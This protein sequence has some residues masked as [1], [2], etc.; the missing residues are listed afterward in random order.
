M[1]NRI[2]ALFLCIGMLLCLCACNDGHASPETPSST[3]PT[4]HTEPS[5]ST[6]DSG[7]VI[8]PSSSANDLQNPQGNTSATAPTDRHSGVQQNPDT[9]YLV[10]HILTNRQLQIYNR[11]VAAVQNYEQEIDF[12]NCKSTDLLYAFSAANKYNPDLFWFP[13][14]YSMN[15]R[16]T[17]YT[18]TLYYPYSIEQVAWMSDKLQ[19]AVDRLLTDLPSGLDA[20]ATELYLHD[21]L[22]AATEY[23]FN[24]RTNA[25]NAYGALVD[26]SAVCEGYARA[27][28]LLLH[29]SGLECLLVNGTLDDE[30]HMWNIVKLDGQ[31]Y[32]LDP[33]LND[34]DNRRSH[35][36]FNLTDLAISADHTIDRQLSANVN[37]IPLDLDFNLPIPVCGEIAACYFVKTNSMI[38]TDEHLE[39]VLQTKLN[40]KQ[41][42]AGDIIELGFADTCSLSYPA[43]GSPVFAAFEN[44]ISNVVFAAGYYKFYLT[45]IPGSKG[46]SIRIG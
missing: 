24:Y 37:E 26:G 8:Q 22:V 39:S 27:M 6:A 46:F 32:H 40:Q 10:G 11:I 28:Q 21:R 4:A 15:W 23:D 31:W 25:F 29:K 9:Q 44:R 19:E 17:G 30:G 1:H 33:T 45:G 38:F 16:R 14:Q 18:L 13:T 12:P 36:Y 2:A 42:A 3:P 7:V 34:S 41:Y 5:D 20:Y 35:A 43:A